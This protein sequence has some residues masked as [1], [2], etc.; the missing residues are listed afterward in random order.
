[1]ENDKL[2]ELR[3]YN[4]LTQKNVGEIIGVR[5]QTYAEWEKGKKIIPLKHLVTLA[6]YYNVS[7]DYL[8]G[9]SNKK[10]IFY[11]YVTLDKKEIG[12]KVVYVR[13]LYN[14]NQKD[15]ASILNTSS[16][17]I[18]AYEKGKTLILTAFLYQIAKKYNI[19]IDWLVGASSKIKR[20]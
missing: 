1:M 4:N 8:T 3:E 2:F 17:T 20:N 18:C 12:K 15:L 13:S 9:L 5:Q 7:L 14:I 11:K 6:K 10:D 19:S 16:S